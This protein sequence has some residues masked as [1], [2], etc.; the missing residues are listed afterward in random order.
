VWKLPAGTSGPGSLITLHAFPSSPTATSTDGQT[1]NGVIADSQGNVFG[2]AKIGPADNSDGMLFEISASGTYTILHNFVGNNTAVTPPTYDGYSPYLAPIQGID[3]NLYGT[4]YLGGNGAANGGTNSNGTVW[5]YPLYYTLTVA[6]GGTGT[7]TVTSSDGQ[8]SCPGTCSATY[9]TGTQVTLTETPNNTSSFGGWSGSGSVTGYAITNAGPSTC[10]A[11]NLTISA[12]DAP[13]GVQATGIYTCSGSGATAYLNYAFITN[14]GSGYV[15]VPTATV[16]SVGGTGTLTLFGG[17]SSIG[18]GVG[19]GYTVTNSGSGCVAGNLNISAPDIP[20]GV[21]AAGTYTCAGSGASARLNTV[22]ITNTGSGYINVPTATMATGTGT[23]TLSLNGASGAVCS[24]TGSTCT[25]TVNGG[26]EVTPTFNARASQTIGFTTNAPPSATYSTSFGVAATAS[27]GLTVA[28]SALGSCSVVDNGNGTAYYTMT[29]GAGTC[30]VL[31]DQ[32]GNSSYLPATEVTEVVSATPASQTIACFNIPSY[33]GYNSNFTVTCS[34]GG[35]GNPVV[36]TS[37]GGC[38]N[39]GATY[40]MTSSTTACSVI[41]NQA[42][43]MNYSAAPQFSQSVTVTLGTN[44]VTFPTPAPQSAEYGSTFTVVAAGLGTG[45]ITYTSDGAVCT[46]V[47]S[48]YAMI[49]GTGTCTVTAT[50]AADANYGS[51]SA[52]ESVSATPSLVSVSVGTS[53]DPVTYGQPVTF[54]ATVTSDTGLVRGRGARGRHVKS[55]QVSGS[56]NWSDDTGCVTTPLSGDPAQATC[57]TSILTGGTDTVT[58]TYPSNAN[59]TGNSGSYSQTVSPASQA[60]TLSNVPASAVYGTNFTVTATGGGSGNPVTF[61]S[62]GACGNVGATYTITAPEGTCSVIADQAGNQNYAAAPEVTQ[63]VSATPLPASVAITPSV[64]PSVYGQPVTFTATIGSAS[65]NVRR[66]NGRARAQNEPVTGSVVWSDD[67]GCGTTT[68]TAGNPG[69]ATCTTSVLATGTDAVTANYS[70]DSNNGSASAT[71]NQAVN[72]ANAGVTVTSSGT[73]TYGEP[74]TFTATISGQYGLVKSKKPR[75][76]SGTVAWSDDTGCGTTTV[77]SGNPGTAT[78]TTS[79]LAAGSYTITANYSGDSNHGGG[80]GSVSQT[81]NQASQTIKVTVGPPATAAYG[82]SFTVVATATSG[83]QVSY[84]SSGACTNAGATYTMLT[85]TTK[86]SGTVCNVTLTQVGN[87]NYLAASPYSGSTT[88][89]KAK[90]PTVSL[91]APSLTANQAVYNSTFTVVATTNASTT[92]TI[93]ASGPCTISGTAVTM[94]SGTGSCDLEASWPADDVYLAATAKL[95]VK[96]TKEAPVISVTGVPA[97]ATVGSA[98]TVTTSSN[99]SGSATAVPTIKAAPGSV[100]AAG[101]VNYIGNGNY[102]TTV[103]TSKAGTC[104]TT[105]TW[106]ATSDYAVASATG[107]TTA[108]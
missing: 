49:S 76:V 64:N 59:H 21:Q 38:S 45:A 7:G 104:T 13:T 89:A 19:N 97:T 69:T 50:Q 92:A 58:A 80:S 94:T 101:R 53:Q 23:L 79:S 66:R 41:A 87:S 36:Y 54:T 74:V 86:T 83:L 68:V 73:S 88:I 39:S 106:P 91:T 65:G 105:V 22:F 93:T 46:N 33:A 17:S 37:S 55:R 3:G 47:G 81:V 27:S 51:A 103:A 99:E 32:A 34:G 40:T 78:C 57:T 70:G 18:E 15:N 35:S 44:S 100:C 56:V 14:P 107:T 75:D 108:Q 95:T 90:K 25:V 84:A 16:S 82:T 102:Q 28:F 11:G 60:I 85:K 71:I 72:L 20:S 12:P 48:T 63:S 52:S 30:S 24:G 4:T 67:T 2:T 31:A 10:K 8:I 29:S 1:P 43:N 42:A 9:Y 5:G 98:F 6:P 96:A 61:T 77:T 26:I 62:A